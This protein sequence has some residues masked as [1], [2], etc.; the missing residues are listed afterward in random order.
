[1]TKETKKK[2]AKPTLMLIIGANLVAGLPAGAAI[3]A[4]AG[5]TATASSE[6]NT[7]TQA[8]FTIDQSGLTVGTGEYSTTN[9]VSWFAAKTDSPVSGNWIQW[10]L[11]DVYTLTTVQVWNVNQTNQG[12]WINNGIKG[13]DIYVSGAVAPGDPEGAGA[14]NW[15]L[16]AQDATFSAGSGL[17]TYT[18]FDLATEVG[19]ALPASEIR[20][21]R[22]EVDSIIGTPT[23]NYSSN[24]GLAEIQF[25]GT[26]AAIPEP[27]SLLLLGLG[28]GLTLLR[29]RRHG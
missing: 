22:F 9:A 19:Q 7:N 4:G 16:W 1:M 29:R 24:A 23:Q 25:D 21:V 17:A 10:D 8:A 18:G 15:T 27:G 20:W 12:G 2:T 6:Y 14:A 26:V 3:I 5:I 28:G 13:V 11:G